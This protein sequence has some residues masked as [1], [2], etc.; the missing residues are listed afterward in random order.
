V[1]TRT[2]RLAKSTAGRLGSAV[3]SVAATLMSVV[4]LTACGANFGAQ[5]NQIYQPADGVNYREG[6]VY[7][8]G[9]LV[10]AD[11]AGH[12]TVVAALINS[13]EQPDSLT[14]IGATDGEGGEI[15]VNK[16]AKP[17]ELEP[18]G[19]LQLADLGKIALTGDNLEA[20][21]VVTLTFMF[22]RAESV[23]LEVPVVPN[24]GDYAEVTIP[25]ADS[26]AQPEE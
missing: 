15:A 9:T 23:T 4:A 7:A 14:S 19:A 16:L 12:G 5:T 25:T 20:G 21:K 2:T 8:M 18:A 24:T 17:L 10:V 26:S 13:T 3:G 22:E 11:D 1:R 6:D